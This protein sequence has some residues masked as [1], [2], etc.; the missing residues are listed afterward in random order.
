MPSTAPVLEG[1]GTKFCQGDEYSQGAA[2]T[3]CAGGGR[4]GAAVLVQLARNHDP[5]HPPSQPPRWPC[6][7]VDHTAWRT[8]RR[9][10]HPSR[11]CRRSPRRRP[12]SRLPASGTPLPH[13]LADL[14]RSAARVR[15][16]PRTTATTTETTSAGPTA[17]GETTRRTASGGAGGTTTTA[18]GTVLAAARRARTPT[19]STGGGGRGRPTSTRRRR[20]IARRATMTR[21]EAPPQRQLLDLRMALCQAR[22]SCQRSTSFTTRPAGATRPTSRTVRCTSTAWPSFA[23]QEVRLCPRSLLASGCPA[24]E[25]T[26]G[27][28]SQPAASSACRVTT[29]SRAS[30]T[31]PGRARC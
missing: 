15:A 13:P 1:R 8:R 7:P 16:R 12:L 21:A 26:P 22:P 25:L 5:L 6:C 11:P 23:A 24:L 30:R 20:G 18:V 17:G 29:R 14:G 10:S 2:T 9:L 31:R 28:S 19:T 4:E 3:P 27:R